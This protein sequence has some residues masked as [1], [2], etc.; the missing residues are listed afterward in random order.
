MS[1]L[2]EKPTQFIPNQTFSNKMKRDKR[3]TCKNIMHWI[4]ASC[5]LDT[6]Q[7]KKFMI[8]ISSRIKKKNNWMIPS[9]WQKF[10]KK[11]NDNQVSN[12]KE[13]LEILH[14]FYPASPI[15]E[16]HIRPSQAQIYQFVV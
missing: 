7:I 9:V 11:H 1:D 15:E 6:Q 3:S 16:R 2:D 8:E 10:Y 14:A 5:H 12:D 13:R 4:S